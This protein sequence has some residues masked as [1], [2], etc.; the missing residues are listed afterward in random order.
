MLGKREGESGNQR[1]AEARD[2]ERGGGARLLDRRAD[3]GERTTRR[4]C[5]RQRGRDRAVAVARGRGGA[6]CC[7]GGGGA[8]RRRRSGQAATLRQRATNATVA[9]LTALY[10]CVGQPLRHKQL[11]VV[12]TQRVY[13]DTHPHTHTAIG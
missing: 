2:G 6:A 8:G 11:V 10:G 12:Q 3:V 4:A 9:Q 5:N 13:Y 7:S 1:S